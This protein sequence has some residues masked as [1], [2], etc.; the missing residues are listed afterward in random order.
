MSEDGI[1]RINKIKAD[2]AA[3][4]INE[5]YDKLKYR[6]RKSIHRDGKKDFKEI[7]HEKEEKAEEVQKK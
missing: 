3:M 5:D 2:D 6:R 1:D 7:L 4:R